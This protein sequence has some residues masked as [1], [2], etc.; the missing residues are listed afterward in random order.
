VNGLTERLQKIYKTIVDEEFPPSI[1]VSF[2]YDTPQK[3]HYEKV[4]WTVN[5][6]GEGLVKRG[7]RYG[8]N[9]GQPAALYK[10]TNGNLVMGDVQTIQPGKWLASDM[11]LLQLGR[12]PGKINITDVDNALNLLRYFEDPIAAILKHNNPCGVALGNTI[13]DAYMKANRADRLAAF[14]GT[15]AL[16]K[17]VDEK[18]A[19]AILNNVP[20]VVAAPDYD[21]AALEVLSNRKS[22]RVMKISNI[23]RLKKWSGETVVDFKSL[24]D[25]GVI[26]QTSYVPNARSLDDIQKLPLAYYKGRKSGK[27]LSEIQRKPTEKEYKDMWFGWLVQSV[28]SSNSVIYVKDGITVGIGIGEQDRVGAAKIAR[29]KAYEKLADVICYEKTGGLPLNVVESGLR[30]EVIS[31][32]K[33]KSLYDALDDP[34]ELKKK[35]LE[36]VKS[37]NGGLKGSTI[38]SDGL[39]PFMDGVVVGLREGATA[40]IQPGGSINDREVIKACNQYGATMLFS[41][42]RSFKH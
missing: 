27:I 30:K 37:V 22:M 12:H 39:F 35:V 15:I 8:E 31:D 5:I 23:D 19:E 16:N 36:E 21:D 14:G 13:K 42:Q 29:D 26:L 24:I 38:S 10:L 32:K 1:T 11:E 18:L 41:G 7:L 34:L 6:E 40:V 3:L 25:G 33:M 28:L 20:D 17:K 4:T 2:N 9:P